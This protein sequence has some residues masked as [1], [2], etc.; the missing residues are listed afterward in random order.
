MICSIHTCNRCKAKASEIFKLDD[1]IIYDPSFSLMSF[2]PNNVYCKRCYAIVYKICIQTQEENFKKKGIQFVFRS[3]TLKKKSTIDEYKK[4][5]K[6]NQCQNIKIVEESAVKCEN[7]YSYIF[8]DGLNFV[9]RYCQECYEE[10]CNES[11]SQYFYPISSVVNKSSFDTT[12][13][14]LK[15]KEKAEAITELERENIL[16]KE[17]DFANTLLGEIR[18]DVPE[19]GNLFTECTKESK[20]ESTKNKKEN[21]K[22]KTGRNKYKKSTRK[23]K[24]KGKDSTR[25]N[26]DKKDSTEEDTKESE[27]SF[28]SDNIKEAYLKL[29]ISTKANVQEIK[30]AYRTMALLYHPDKNTSDTTNLFRSINEAYLSIKE[31]LNFF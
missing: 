14:E 22:E 19:Y 7:N 8:N 12:I 3:E 24:G 29:D 20:R 16:E 27:E 1:H 2:N 9:K 31:Y 10:C 4:K 5:I 25:E 15:L 11:N 26:K 13:N 23:E 30:K 28:L 6:F 18:V 21:G 17:H